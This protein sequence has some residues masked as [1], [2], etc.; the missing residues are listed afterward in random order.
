MNFMEIRCML[1]FKKIR[2]CN[3]TFLNFYWLL[4]ESREKFLEEYCVES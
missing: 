2:A 3:Y 4:A 1:I